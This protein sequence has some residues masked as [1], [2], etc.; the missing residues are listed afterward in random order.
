MA[1]TSLD[2]ALAGMLQPYAFIKVGGT[3]EAAGVMHSLA[4]STGLPG[5]MTAPSSGLAGA[6]IT[7]RTGLTSV[8]A[9]S[10][11]NLSYLAGVDA[12]ASVAG[13]LIIVDRLW[14]N[15]GAVVTTTTGQTV[16]SA[17]WPARDRNGATDGDQVMIGIEASAAT[18]NASAVTNTTIT[19]TD[20]GGTGSNTG[21]MAS[22]PA[23]AAAGTF[24][25]F[26]LAAGDTGVRSIQTLTLGTSYV[27]GT[28]HLV[29]YRELARV[30]L[31]VA[32]VGATLD[33]IATSFV[34]LYDNTTLSLLWLPTATTATTIAGKIT[35]SQG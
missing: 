30:S 19:Y 17:T 6:A 4:Y 8:P 20:S 25:P 35:F 26:Q 9:P 12:A 10:G 33:A 23:T 13:Q 32:N 21:T 34:R 3:M 1:I 16:N 7:S 31:P 22:W 15:S 2:G 18:T 11:A 5:A 14:D 29:A 28:I 24:V 27:T